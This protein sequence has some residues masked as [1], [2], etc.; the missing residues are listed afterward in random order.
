M[1]LHCTTHGLPGTTGRVSEDALL[2]RQREECT[3]AALADGLGSAQEGRNAARRA[4]EMMTDYYSARPQ[5]WGPRRALSEFAQRI[6]R[7]FFQESQMRHGAPELLCTLSV[8]AVE[9][10]VVHGL[11]VGDSPIFHFR[12]GKLTRL[13]EKHTFPQPEM[14]HVL[15]RAIGLAET[16]DPSYFEIALEVG[17]T[18]LLCSDG[19]SC[20]LPEMRINELLE[21]RASAR[22]VVTAAREIAEDNPELSDDASAIVIEITEL[23]WRTEGQRRDLEVLSSL[24]T[25]DTIDE[26]V[27]VRALQ[28]GDRVWVARTPPGELKVLKFPPLEAQRDDVRRDAFLREAWQATRVESADFVRAFI[29]ST[30]A[31]RYYVMD[32]VE[33]PTLRSLLASRS[34]T[35]EETVALARFLLRAGQFL[36][37]HDLAH[38]DI[39]PENI[40]V[41]RSDQGINFKLLDLGSMAE[42]FSV[43][44]R[45]GT[46]SYLAPER[47]R[48]SAISERTEI[49]SI[50]VT[51][52]EAITQSFPYGEIERFQT[53]RFESSPRRI[54]RQNT[55]VPA[56]LDSVVLRALAPEP[57]RRYQN[58]SEMT[59][60]LDHPAQVAPY[61]RKDAPLLERNPLLVYKAL[62]AI[63]LLSN[64]LLL[65][66]LSHR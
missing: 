48:E 33:A 39:K 21:R 12:K 24:K 27:L 16:L 7:L 37:K 8:V 45:A 10:N 1:K 64:I 9:G 18:L 46:A 26:Y 53:P 56:W 19:V 47:F 15:T 22:T 58:F 52:Y 44:S 23:A 50:G 66:R 29:P 5:A 42:I 40:L 61:Y 30:K 25:G 49:F 6:N 13:S 65:Y 55:A 32:Y 3:V 38:G 14:E 41:L 60:D 54:S 2:L 31:L 36:L 34:L 43:T 28:E 4:V 62:C 11:N 57:E 51:L 63:L 17:D 35:I 59:F 20:A